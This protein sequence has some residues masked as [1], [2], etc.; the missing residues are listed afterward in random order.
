LPVNF[1]LTSRSQLPAHFPFAISS[2]LPF[3]FQP[4]F[5]STKKA[6]SSFEGRGRLTKLLRLFYVI[7]A[8]VSPAR[9]PAKE[10]RYVKANRVK[11]RVIARFL[12]FFR[13]RE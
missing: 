2:S 4:Y 10:K 8:R 6:A 13:S 12:I 7:S 1:Q 3:D 5:Y 11:V 9:S